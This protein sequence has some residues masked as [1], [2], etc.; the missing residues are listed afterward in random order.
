MQAGDQVITY[1][2]PAVEASGYDPVVIVV[3]VE[4]DPARV[5]V[6]TRPGAYVAMLDP[7]LTLKG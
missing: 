4:H 2:V 3:V 1:D 6:D 7:L 5:T